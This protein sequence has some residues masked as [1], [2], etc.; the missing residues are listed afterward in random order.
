MGKGRGWKIGCVLAVLA[1]MAVPVA[2]TS[3]SNGK[4]ETVV[5]VAKGQSLQSVLRGMEKNGVIR[6]SNVALL[7]SRFRGQTSIK[8]GTYVVRPNANMHDALSDLRLS[9]NSSVRAPEGYW[10]ARTGQKLQS[11]GFCSEAEYVAA[12]TEIAKESELPMNGSG[13]GFLFPDTYTL[14]VNASASDLVAAQVDQFE[15]KVLP[16]L[17][18]KDIRRILTIASMVEVEASDPKE[19]KMVAG[20]IENRLKKGMRLE[21]DATVLYAMQE[22]KVLGPGVVRTVVSP[23]NT[24]LNA[25]LPPGPICSPSLSSIKAAIEP[26]QH[27]YLFYNGKGD[28]KHFFSKTYEEHQGNIRK[29]RLLSEAQKP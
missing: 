25:G 27:D 21:I 2:M 18:G 10:I 6:S 23:Y 20:V 14:A 4:P 26:D 8:A 13:E 7:L 28:D 17:K 12:A 11:T 9:V 24:Y 5:S 22:W 1:A 15:E 16:L 19:R 29:A 3:I